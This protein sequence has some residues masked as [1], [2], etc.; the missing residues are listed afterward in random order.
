[1]VAA[2]TGVNSAVTDITISASAATAPATRDIGTVT[3]SVVEVDEYNID[4][5]FTVDSTGSGAVNPEIS[6]EVE[7]V[8][9]NFLTAPK[10]AYV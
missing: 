5:Q 9:V 1:M 10:I 4:V 2:G 3:M 8:W 6:C 7:V